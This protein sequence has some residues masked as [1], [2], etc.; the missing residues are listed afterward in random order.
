MSSG[1]SPGKKPQTLQLKDLAGSFLGF[2]FLDIIAQEKIL[3]K[4][5]VVR[6]QKVLPWDIIDGPHGMYLHGLSQ[7]GQWLDTCHPQYL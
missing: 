6:V 4:D 5:P 3:W 1:N 2:F 7:I